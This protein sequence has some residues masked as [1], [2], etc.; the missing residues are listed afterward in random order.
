MGAPSNV[1]RVL[2]PPVV[3]SPL[4]PMTRSTTVPMFDFTLVVVRPSF[5]STQA[6]ACAF[7]R[8]PIRPPP[9]SPTMYIDVSS[10]E[11]FCPVDLVD[12]VPMN[13][14]CALEREGGNRESRVRMPGEWKNGA[15]GDEQ[16]LH[17][18]HPE[19]LIDDAKRGA[20]R[21]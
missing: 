10:I 20:Q 8:F 18:V 15:I 7:D 17:A 12:R 16:V 14:V 1:Y 19:V 6:T 13:D 9:I 4:M 3:V 5:A 11:D 21:H 2:P